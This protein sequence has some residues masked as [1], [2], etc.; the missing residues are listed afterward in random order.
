M[1][2]YDLLLSRY[3]DPHWWPGDTPYE[4]IVG[5]VLTQNTAWSNV[6]KALANFGGRLSPEYVAG[7]DVETLAEIIRP[8]GFF[9]QK[10]R[11]L[12]EIT[13]WFGRYGYDAHVARGMP[14][15]RIRT[16]LLALRGVGRETADD[17]LLY[18]FQ[19]STFVVDAYTKRLTERLRIPAG[20]DYE[21]VKTFFEERLPCDEKLF[22]R[23]HALIVLNAKEHCR[24]KPICSGCPLEGVCIGAIRASNGGDAVK[25]L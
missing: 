23:Y 8:S 15:D 16:E 24:K 5:A 22:N 18:A 20:N 11:Y 14:L 25:S 19:F 21:S 9:N 7:L 3:G 6:K 10:A 17:I 12:Q 13:R 2:I 1:N 4:I